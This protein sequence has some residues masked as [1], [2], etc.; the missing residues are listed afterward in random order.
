MAEPP[1]LQNGPGYTPTPPP[2]PRRSVGSFGRRA[3]LFSML[4]PLVA[5]TMAAI[6]MGMQ[7]SPDGSGVQW[8]KIA[9]GGIG[10]LLVL[11]GFVLAIIALS[12]MTRDGRR[13]ILGFALAG[14]ILNASVVALGVI[15]L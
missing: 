11:A 8:G 10:T 12:L 4:A 3:A 6:L 14:L 9:V 5:I 1:M 2:L 7:P 15:P 13:G